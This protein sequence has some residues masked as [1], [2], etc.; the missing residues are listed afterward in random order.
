MKNKK[1][2]IVFSAMLL[3]SVMLTNVR[4]DQIAQVVDLAA[5]GLVDKQT[6][7]GD[8]AGTWVNEIDF[9][10]TMVAGL[11]RAYQ[12][13]GNPD[14]LTA[15]ELGGQA[16]VQL[17]DNL[18]GD[19]AYA[20]CLLS[21]VAADPDSNQ[22]RSVVSDFYTHVKTTE[23]GGTQ[24]YI[25]KFTNTDPSIATY[26]L[27]YHAMAA[28]YV[29]AADKAVYRAGILQYLR[30][31]DDDL[32]D[33]P[34]MA[35]GV[36]T[37]GLS[38]TGPLDDTLVRPG[39]GGAPVWN[40]VKLSDLPAMLASFQVATGGYAG[41]FYWR[42]DKSGGDS[43]DAGYVE[44]LIYGLLGLVSGQQACPE[45]DVAG[46][47][48]AARAVLPLAVYE[49]S[50]GKGEVY[51]HVWASGIKKN[52]YAGELLQALSGVVLVGD[53]NGDGC[54]NAADLAGFAANWLDS[55][56][57]YPGWCGG[58]D[59]NHDG[60]VNLHDFQLLSASWGICY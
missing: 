36:A 10:G 50:S 59:L 42:F 5:K 16:I 23:A 60:M 22:W 38:Q 43:L 24:G 28:A 4:A 8:Y 37:W 32:V 41:S 25:N 51:E 47:I 6:K 58:S 49:Y 52:Y 2:C 29:N 39:S 44:E 21:L 48:T 18:Y 13:T 9:T 26:Y 45:I 40:G 12:A 35:L 34:V 20:L 54:V 3:I 33:Y 11:V 31:V 17:S 14:Y 15:A 7:D 55:G 30:M 46:S 27:S 19:E 53:I 1:V 56:C 57:A